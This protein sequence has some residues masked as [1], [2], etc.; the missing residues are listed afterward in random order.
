M[1]NTSPSVPNYA[2]WFGYGDEAMLE[3]KLHRDARALGGEHP[4]QEPQQPAAATGDGHLS[5]TFLGL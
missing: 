5:A 3:W 1:A 4:A 2:D